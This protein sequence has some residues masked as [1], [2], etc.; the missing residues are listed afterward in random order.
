MQSGEKT[1][2][3]IVHPEQNEIAQS[4]ELLQ[5]PAKTPTCCQ[6]LVH[7]GAEVVGVVVVVVGMQGELEL[8]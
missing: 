1:L 7:M 3:A 5:G 4:Q 8:R 2:Q 6:Q